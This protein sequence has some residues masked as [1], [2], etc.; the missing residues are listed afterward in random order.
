[1]IRVHLCLSVAANFRHGF[2]LIYTDLLLGV[3]CPNRLASYFPS[4]EFN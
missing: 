2:A 3:W 1:M 4:Q